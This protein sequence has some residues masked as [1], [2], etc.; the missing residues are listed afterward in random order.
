MNDMIPVEDMDIREG[1]TAGELM[2]QLYRSGGFVAK[3]LAIA[4]KILL[5]MFSE[6]NTTFLSF[7]AC[8]IATGT[9]GVIKELVKRKLVDVIITTCGTLDH[10]IARSFKS[11]Y[12]GSFLLDDVEL[13]RM[14]VNRLGN[15]LVP[16]ESYGEVME[17]FMM[18]ILEELYREKKEWGPREII[19]EFGKRLGEDSIL[20]WAHKNNIP[21]YV[22][23]ITDGSFGSQLWSFREMHPDFRIDILKDEHELADIVFDASKTG[24]L[25]LGGGI[26]KHHT[27]WWNQFRE[28]LDYAVYITTAVEWDGSLSG[29]RVREAVS[30]GKVRE[31]AKYVTVEGDV[32]V[33]LP[34]LVASVL[35]K[36]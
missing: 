5:R 29:A 23:G 8:I 2:D 24:A 27:I 18:P 12:H 19:E 22:P 25:M 36:L 4:E 13:H 6:E 14:G 1:M 17:N 16:N 3:H 26:S 30:W 15:V 9:R 34:L 11:Y 35:E 10:D 32:T 21:V 31:D 33:I 28:G 20:Y 7:P